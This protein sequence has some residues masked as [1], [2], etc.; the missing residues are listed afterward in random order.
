MTEDL[1]AYFHQLSI[2]HFPRILIIFLCQWYPFIHAH[3]IQRATK[4]TKE[5]HTREKITLRIPAKYEG[6][7][8]WKKWHSRVSPFIN[9][10]FNYF[11]HSFYFSNYVFSLSLFIF[12]A[13]F[14]SLFHSRVL[15]FYWETLIKLCDPSLC[16]LL[17]EYFFHSRWVKG[18]KKKR[19]IMYFDTIRFDSVKFGVLF[20]TLMSPKLFSSCLAFSFFRLF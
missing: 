13:G 6:D 16:D 17:K 11:F 14:F 15:F 20:L 18:I 4:R 12:P 8:S 19:N 2:F 9:G 1:I 7:I 10:D 5:W 3:H